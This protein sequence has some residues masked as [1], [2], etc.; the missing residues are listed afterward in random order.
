MQSSV[1]TWKSSLGIAEVGSRMVIFQ[2]SKQNMGSIVSFVCHVD[3]F[4]ITS[5][6]G[7]VFVK[8]FIESYISV[9]Y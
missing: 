3:V 4:K 1:Y 9:L 7:F 2:I 5:V 6:I 8:I